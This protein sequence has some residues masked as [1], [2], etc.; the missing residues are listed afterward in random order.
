MHECMSAHIIICIC[1]FIY[2]NPMILP[3]LSRATQQLEFQSKGKLEFGIITSAT[4]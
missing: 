4:Q 3:I 2:F 1:I